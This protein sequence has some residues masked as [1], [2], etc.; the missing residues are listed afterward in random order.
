[1]EIRYGTLEI[2]SRNSLQKLKFER[3]N[4]KRLHG[5]DYHYKTETKKM[6]K[7]SNWTPGLKVCVKTYRVITEIIRHSGM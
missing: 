1:M 4:G 7:K 6:N 3:E 2:I 5:K